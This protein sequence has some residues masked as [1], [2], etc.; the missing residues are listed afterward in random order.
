MGIINL[1]VL[2]ALWLWILSGSLTTQHL[3]GLSSYLIQAHPLALQNTR[4]DAFADEGEQKML[5]LNVMMVETLHFVHRQL[6][7]FLGGRRQPDDTRDSM[8]APTDEELN[9]AANFAKVNA[10]VMQYLPCYS[11]AVA[12]K[13]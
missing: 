11:I 13:A 12:D 5:G 10:K 2:E 3:D 9:G 6:D 1:M 7:D 8:I 4:G